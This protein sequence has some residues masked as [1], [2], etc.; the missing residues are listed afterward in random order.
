MPQ[1]IQPTTPMILTEE[2]MEKIA[3]KAADKAVAKITSQVYQQIGKGVVT[4][5]TWILGACVVALGAWLKSEGK[6]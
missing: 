1:D 4:R 3:E 5:A 2:Q 6:L